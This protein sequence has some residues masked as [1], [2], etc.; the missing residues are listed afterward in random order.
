MSRMHL[1][2][3]ILS[4]VVVTASSLSAQDSPLLIRGARVFDGSAAIG[5]RDVLVQGGRISR[6]APSIAAPAGATIVDGKGKTLLPGLID[7]HTH[8]FRDVL[9]Q[10]LAFG[11]TT[12][13]EMFTDHTTAATWRAEQ[14]AGRAND[15]ADVFSAGI[16]V[17]APKGHGT[18][19]GM[20]IP[21]IA[22][23]DSA[24]QFV[25]ARI[26]EGSDY[27]KIVYDDGSAY[28]MKL[29]TIDKPTLRAVIEAAH[30]RGK[31]A[32]VHVGAAAGARDA[33]ESGADGLVHIHADR[34][35]QADIEFLRLAS[36]N[37]PFVIPTLSVNMSVTGAPG[38]ADLARD[39]RIEPALTAT[40]LSQLS[41][42]FPSRPGSKVRYAYAESTV[43]KLKTAGVPIV[44]GS[45]A[46]NP[47]TTHGASMHGEMEKLVR[48]GLTPTEALAAATSVPAGVF[49][50]T[51]R[52]RIASGLRADLLLV[53][54]D[55]TVDITSTRA[56]A[57]IWKAG[58]AFDREA[59]V[60]RAA[61]TRA[62]VGRAPPGSESGEISTF[63]DGTTG[64][65]FGAGWSTSTDQMAGGKSVG[66]MEV[67]SGGANGT[68]K[69]LRITGTIDGALPYAWA[70]AAFSPG[71]APM[72]PAD[73]SAK[74]E[75]VFWARGD[76]KTQRV[77]LFA[78]SRGMTPLV[79]TFQ[80]SS[81]WKEFAFPLSAFGTDG[82]DVLLL[83]IA[84]GPT[85][86]SFEMFVD[87]VRVR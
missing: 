73:L 36:A 12:Q 78:Q 35:S 50:L 64:S 81:E 40:D 27:I 65:K 48:A 6:V 14:R 20:A 11:V 60:K 3:L 4:L 56:I 51:D 87:E 39:P 25:D 21:T 31:L 43:M 80:T 44:A 13:L 9:R 69:A 15:R 18:Q 38:G 17:T 19:F 29:A 85:P 30:K 42:A 26:A 24:Q 52:G 62:T 53:S 16:L 57:G 86:G 61:A 28:G 46:P 74:K 58:V 5:V 2:S 10:A 34:D 33:I 82:K 71:S 76:G 77:M 59:Y 70:G 63:D 54:G 22:T 1:R 83:L 23:P 8:T 47:G 49:R 45:D 84:G 55:P 41:Q 32:V 68:P 79:Q 72:Q 66:T 75:I 67:V 37:R 7:A